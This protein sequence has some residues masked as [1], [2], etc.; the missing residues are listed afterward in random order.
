M[1]TEVITLPS[2][3]EIMIRLRSVVD[4]RHLVVNFYPRITAHAGEEFTSEGLELMLT[5][6]AYDYTS[7]S[8]PEMK[9]V[10]SITLPRLLRVLTERK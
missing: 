1:T 2:A 8:P 6:A 3:D 7:A 5:L 10:M 4:V 9:V